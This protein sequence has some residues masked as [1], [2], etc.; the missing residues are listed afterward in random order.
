MLPAAS[1]PNGDQKKSLTD[2]FLIDLEYNGV[3]HGTKQFGGR[4]STALPAGSQIK[5]FE[6]NL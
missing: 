2:V 6:V 1:I 3:V 5:F 4:G